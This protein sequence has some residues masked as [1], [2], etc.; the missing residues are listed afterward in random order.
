M[1]AG[2]RRY[3]APAGLAV[4]RSAA[5]LIDS[6]GESLPPKFLPVPD[7]HLQLAATGQPED[8][9]V[10]VVGRFGPHFAN[11]SLLQGGR[12]ASSARHRKVDA[13]SS[14]TVPSQGTNMPEFRSGVVG[15]ARTKAP[16]TAKPGY[17]DL[18]D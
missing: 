10:V 9:F 1:S 12:G 6:D 4:L 18:R 3:F 8:S 2:F 15:A 13:P 5:E 14:K 11:I 7:A 17:Q 16:T